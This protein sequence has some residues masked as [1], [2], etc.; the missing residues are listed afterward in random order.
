[1]SYPYSESLSFG[2]NYVYEKFSSSD[3]QLDGVEPS[4]IPNLLSMSAD[5]W[6]YDTSVVYLNV[7]YQLGN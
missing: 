6:N 3:W 4:T 1:M 2:L 5:T 7:R